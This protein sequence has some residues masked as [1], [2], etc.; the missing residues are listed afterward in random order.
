M[1]APRKDTK[2]DAMHALYQEGFSLS[3][4]GT[5]FSVTRQSVHK[6]FA[7]RGFVLRQRPKPL[8]FIELNGLR[9]TRRRDGYFRQ[10][11]GSRSY[12]HRD[13]WEATHGPIPDGHDIHHID[14]DQSNN[15]IHNLEQFT[16]SEHGKHHI[17]TNEGAKRTRFK[18]GRTGRHYP[19]KS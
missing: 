16:S 1:P 14:G 9:Y 18:P 10:T 6:M 11:L 13:I 5:A 7:K 19:R 2:A 4:V 3:Q 15:V 12:L 17:K 8:P